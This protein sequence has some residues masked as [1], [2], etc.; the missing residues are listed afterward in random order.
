MSRSKPAATGS[1]SPIEVYMQFKPGAGV[2]S[3]YDKENDEDVEM[4][5]VEIV[6]L[7]VL[8]SITGWFESNDVGTQIS[9][10]M[11]KSINT[12]ELVVRAN[13]N[14]N[15]SSAKTLFKGVYNRDTK[16]DIAEFGGKYTTN[17]ICLANIEGEWKMTRIELT[18]YAVKTW[19]DFTA[20]YPYEG[21]LNFSIVLGR[22]ETKK[23][24]RVKFHGVTFDTTEITP[25]LD[26]MA[27]EADQKFQAFFNGSNE[28]SADNQT[29]VPFEEEEDAPEEEAP[30]KSRSAASSSGSGAKKNSKVG[31]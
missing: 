10:N 30:A 1:K 18:G 15:F 19:T 11:V 6:I 26:A 14:K 28:G 25:E 4:D 17:I 9:S 7:D 16:Q 23:K 8:A 27:L 3:F 5:D 24:G 29:D 31:F 13:K 21:Y 12:D 22:T 20:E 2:F